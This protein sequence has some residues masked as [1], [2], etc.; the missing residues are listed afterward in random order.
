MSSKNIACDFKN[1]IPKGENVC[2]NMQYIHLELI[3]I[4]TTYSNFKIMGL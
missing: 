4:I 1:L 2:H 3:N